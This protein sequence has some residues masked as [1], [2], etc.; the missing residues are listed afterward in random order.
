VATPIV[1]GRQEVLKGFIFRPEIPV[2][3]SHVRDGAFPLL[4]DQFIQ[5]RVGIEIEPGV[6]G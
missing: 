3:H 4:G 5:R 6:V 2:Q 1:K